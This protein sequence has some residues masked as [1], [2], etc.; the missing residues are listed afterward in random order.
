[1]ECIIDLPGQLFHN[2]QI[3]VALWFFN[4]DKS[5]WKNNREGQ[6]LFIDARALG[7]S[8]S[9]TQIEFSSQEIDR[10]AETFRDWT[11]GSFQN[12]DG[13]CRTVPNADILSAGAPLSP[14]RYVGIGHRGEEETEEFGVRMAALVS[15]LAIQ[16]QR[17]RELELEIARQLKGWG[18]EL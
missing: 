2:T 12:I 16:T 15:E 18:Y 7:T 11:T 9:R 14:G 17:S 13:F 10:I 6:V 5:R 1:V 8:V 3:P 4:K